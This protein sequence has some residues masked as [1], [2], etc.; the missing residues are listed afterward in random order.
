MHKL[1]WAASAN[2]AAR[3]VTQFCFDAGAT[4]RFVDELRRAGAASTPVSLG[5]VGPSDRP[6]EQTVRPD[7]A[8]VDPRSPPSSRSTGTTAATA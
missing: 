1:Q 6:A 2:V 7:P 4:A 3:V 5:V 8:T